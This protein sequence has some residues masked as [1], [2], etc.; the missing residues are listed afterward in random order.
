MLFFWGAF[1]IPRI[2]H[3]RCAFTLYFEFIVEAMLP[4]GVGNEYFFAICQVLQRFASQGGCQCHLDAF[5]FP[6]GRRLIECRMNDRS[7]RVRDGDQMRT[8]EKKQTKKSAWKTKKEGNE[9]LH[10]LEAEKIKGRD[11]VI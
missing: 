7:R 1:R 4:E 9:S 10:R 5:A 2:N 11:G 6:S 3:Q 8:A